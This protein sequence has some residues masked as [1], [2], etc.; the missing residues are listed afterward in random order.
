[1]Y[2]IS[3]LK[4]AAEK[5]K[6]H[7]TRSVAMRIFLVILLM[8]CFKWF[9]YLEANK[10][11]T[12]LF[13][14]QIKSNFFIFFKSQIKNHVKSQNL[15]DLTWFDLIWMVKSRK[16]TVTKQPQHSSVYYI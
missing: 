16:L 1:M 11:K 7:V 2:S 4:Q 10:S 5:Q 12:F 13:L 6:Q 3:K 14:R 8:I 15:F 9:Y